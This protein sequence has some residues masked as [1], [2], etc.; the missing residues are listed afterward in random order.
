MSILSADTITFT[1]YVDQERANDLSVERLWMNDVYI[2]QLPL[3]TLYIEQQHE[4]ES[5]L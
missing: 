5:E 4:V 2:T 1:L 3:I